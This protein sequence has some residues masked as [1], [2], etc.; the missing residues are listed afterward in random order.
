MLM[1]LKEI[2]SHNLAMEKGGHLSIPI[3]ER[4]IV[5]LEQFKMNFIYSAVINLRTVFERNLYTCFHTTNIFFKNIRYPKAKFCFS[6]ISS[7]V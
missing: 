3:H 6:Y 2:S 1:Y 7:P 4:I 5:K